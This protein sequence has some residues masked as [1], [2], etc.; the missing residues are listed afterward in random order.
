MGEPTVRV[1]RDA[2]V[3]MRDGCLLKTDI[4]LPEGGRHPVLLLRIP[5]DKELAQ[6]YVYGHP[7]WYA[8]QGFAVVV[9]DTRGRYLSEGQFYP[10]RHEADDA[11]DTLNWIRAQEFA[12]P[13]RIGMYGFSYP[14]KSQ[15]LL[16][17]RYPDAI[18]AMAPGFCGNGMY[19]TTHTGRAF[20]LAMTTSWSIQLAADEARFRGDEDGYWSLTSALGCIHKLYSTLPLSEMAPLRESGRSA[21]YFDMLSHPERDDEYWQPMEVGEAAFAKIQTPALHF[22]GWYDSFINETLTNFERL[23]HRSDQFLLVGPWYH[24]P[25]SPQVGQV[26]FGSEARNVIDEVQLKWFTHWLKTDTTQPI[27]MPRVRL[28]VMG[29]NEWR[30]EDQ[31]PLKRA[32]IRNLYL[33]SG[34]KAN[35]SSGDGMLS[36]EPPDDEPEDIFVYNPLDPVPSLGGNS[37]CFEDLSPMGAYDQ[38]PVEARNDVLVYSTPP[39]DEGVEITGRVTVELYVDFAAPT[40]DFT[41]KLVDVFPDGRAINLCQSV[42]RVE[43]SRNESPQLITF[44]VGATSNFFDKA[45]RIRLEV[46]SSNFPMYERNLNTTKPAGPLSA[47]L[48]TQRVFHRL[49]SPSSLLLPIVE[50]AS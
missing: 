28:F 1:I 33:R 38:R 35:S 44:G 27:D 39:L 46:S 32:E 23:S 40:T 43:K 49:S 15:M 14:G 12:V 4:Y 47:Q 50:M 26:N 13:D 36:M 30:D 22:G 19:D 6:S 5:Y 25:W 48:S 16:A 34:G 8:R 37:C 3:P 24:I 18:T 41:A 31:F 7:V 9:Q 21:F 20:N 2:S 10:L 17:A 11:F 29:R 42:I 45:H